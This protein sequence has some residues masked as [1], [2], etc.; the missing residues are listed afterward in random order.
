MNYNLREFNNK[1]AESSTS[2]LELVDDKMI[3]LQ[4]FNLNKKTSSKNTKGY[5]SLD[6]FKAR[7]MITLIPISSGHNGDISK[8]E[9]DL[10]E[11]VLSK[12]EGCGKFQTKQIL[13][14]F[15]A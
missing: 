12:Y 4:R 3:E 15:Q 8:E 2:G 5:Q 13:E 9:Y 7:S 1:L 14:A 10:F 6:F 11:Q